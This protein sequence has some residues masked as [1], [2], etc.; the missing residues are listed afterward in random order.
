[1]AA[2]RFIFTDFDWDEGN[3]EH[4]WKRH[5]VTPEEVEEVFAGRFRWR[6]GRT[7]KG[8]LYYEGLGQTQSGRYLAVIFQIKPPRIVRIASSRPMSPAERKWYDKAIGP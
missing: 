5:R 4:L 6:K 1:M 3:V 2:A 7:R 8:I